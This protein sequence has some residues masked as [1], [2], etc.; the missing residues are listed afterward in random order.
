MTGKNISPT[1]L[2]TVYALENYESVKSI[3]VVGC[4]GTGAYVIASLSKL[5]S[6]L[7]KTSIS[8]T[9]IDG[10]EVELKNLQ[11]QHFINTDIGK[12]KAEVLARRYSMAYGIKIV[13][14]PHYVEKSSSLPKSQVY[15]GCVDNNKTRKLLY[16]GFKDLGFWIDAGNEERY[17]QVVCGYSPYVYNYHRINPKQ[18]TATKGVFS[19]PCAFDL[20]PNLQTEDKFNSELSCAERAMSAPQN[21]QTNITAANLVMNYLNKII[22]NEPIKSHCV[23]FNIDNVF[24]TRLNTCKNLQKINPKRLKRW[25]A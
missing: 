2:E 16:N 11:R 23:E 4:G 19:L 12:N 6:T 3:V 8:L 24:S 22:H 9:I 5:I 21:M 13:A 14:I 7:E 25:E 15:V 18:D 17:G 1:K 20:Y 10:D